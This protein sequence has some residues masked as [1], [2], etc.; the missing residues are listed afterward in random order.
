MNQAHICGEMTCVRWVTTAA[1]ECNHSVAYVRFLVQGTGLSTEAARMSRIA[2][3][4][5]GVA[6]VAAVQAPAAA[7]ARSAAA[8]QSPRTSASSKPSP[9]PAAKPPKPSSQPSHAAGPTLSPLVTSEPQ[10]TQNCPP[11]PPPQGFTSRVTTEPWAQKALDFSSVWPLTEGQGVE[12]AVVDSGVDFSPQLA[13]KVTAADLTGTGVADC[14]GHGTDVAGIIAATELPDVPFEGVAPEA[15]ILSVKVQNAESSS[16]GSA[17]L[18]LGIR[19]AASLGAKVI[20][21]SITTGNT[22]ALAAAVAFALRQGAV[23]VAA[24]GNDSEETG[25]GPFYPASYAASYRGVLS[26][27]AVASDGSRP[28]YS[29]LRSHVEVTAP[30]DNVTSDCPG[31][32][33]TQ[34]SGTSFATAFVSGVAALV[35]ARYPNL[36]APAV[37]SRIEETANGN[38]GP[39][40]GDGLVNPFQA[41]TAILPS[42]PVASSSPPVRRQPVS[43]TRA[44]LPDRSAI[45]TAT[46]VTAGALGATAVVALGAVVIREGRRRRWRAG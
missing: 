18:A 23:I 32:Y 38:T 27:G 37:V 17:T 12:V 2:V 3:A 33:N 34:L 45:D 11:T 24:G 4:V 6:L 20:N 22:P 35:R 44:P 39:G 8:A 26:V 19:E 25:V 43:V 29:D 15:R 28:S 46:E 13:G 14:V 10:P 21:V 41:V 42:G 30:G 1:K 31:G 16:L 5:L 36:S 9:K 40:T 7:A